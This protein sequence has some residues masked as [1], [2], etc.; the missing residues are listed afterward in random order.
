MRLNHVATAE[1]A[2]ASGGFAP[3]PAGD[4]DFEVH[5]ASEELS[6]ASGREQIKLTLYVFNEDGNKRTVFDYLGSDEKSAWKVRHFCEAIGLL[7]DYESGELD[8]RDIEGKTGRCKLRVKSAQGNFPAG[9][10]V[11]DYLGTHSAAPKAARSSSPPPS[12]PAPTAR[13]R[14]PVDD[15]DDSIPF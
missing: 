12:R 9:N 15:L 2:N 14:V 7:D 5:D 6:K 10:Q 3:W 13:Q 1:E 8:V 11:G 4:Y